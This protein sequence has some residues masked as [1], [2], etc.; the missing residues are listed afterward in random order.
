MI[1][2]DQV[3]VARGVEADAALRVGGHVA[4]VARDVAVRSLVQRDR[5]EHRE[6]VDRDGL[7]ELGECPSW[8]GGFYQTQEFL[9]QARHLFGLVVVQHV[10]RVLHRLRSAGP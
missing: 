1:G 9:D 2:A 3:D 7:D 8:N 10:A 6:R 5:E 4:E